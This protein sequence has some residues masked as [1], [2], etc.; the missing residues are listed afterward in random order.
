MFPLVFRNTF[1]EVER[2]TKVGWNEG[3]PVNLMSYFVPNALLNNNKN[4]NYKYKLHRHA[5]V[6]SD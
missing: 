3:E 1:T 6:R 4:E 2:D 5:T